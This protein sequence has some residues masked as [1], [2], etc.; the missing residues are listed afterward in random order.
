MVEVQVDLSE[1]V[2]NTWYTKIKYIKKGQKDLGEL[3]KPLSSAEL[4]RWTISCDEGYFE[5]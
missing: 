2:S 4:E 3:P 1:N 5:K